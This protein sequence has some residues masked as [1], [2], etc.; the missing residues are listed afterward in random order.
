MKR[1]IILLLIT[2]LSSPLFA[3]DY[4]EMSTQEL[5]AIMGYVEK[6]NV[7]K[8]RKELKSRVPTMSQRERSKYKKNLKKMNK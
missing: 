6:K 7:R 5:I 2:F 4:S 3:V 8:F 1:I